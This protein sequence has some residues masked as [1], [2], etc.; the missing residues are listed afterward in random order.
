MENWKDIKG[1]EGL[2]QVSDTGKVIS[3]RRNKELKQDIDPRGYR[4]VTLCKNGQTERFEVPFLVLETFG[5]KKPFDSATV[6]H[7]DGNP[8]NNNLSNLKWCSLKEN[9]NNP[10]H[11]ERLSKSLMDKGKSVINVTLN[12]EYSSIS[13][14]SRD[15]GIGVSTISRACLGKYKQAGGYVWKFVFQS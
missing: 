8:N 7:I 15:T 12:K 6:D 10:I 3:I 9:N 2:Y 1:Y 11:I 5:F 13:T 4:R 14:A